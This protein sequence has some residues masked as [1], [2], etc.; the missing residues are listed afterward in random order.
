M[1]SKVRAGREYILGIDGGSTTTKVALIDFETDE[2]VADYY[3][4]THGDPV[5]ALKKCLIEVQGQI[6]EQIGDSP[7]NITLS[8]TTG[9]S[10]E[11][12]GVFHGN[13]GNLQ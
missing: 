8:A 7:I 13:S 3:G 4:R 2:I 10:R 6:K 1:R 9:S 5:N 11:I 12:L